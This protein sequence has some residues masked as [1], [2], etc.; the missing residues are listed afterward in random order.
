MSEDR[1]EYKYVRPLPCVR[2]E[3]GEIKEQMLKMLMSKIDEELN[4]F[5][6]AVINH[7]S[8]DLPCVAVGKNKV[9]WMDVAEEAADTI[10]A[11]T[12]LCSALG[13]DADMRSRAQDR[14]NQKNFRRGRL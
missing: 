9:F 14:V 7:Q 13:I 12:T 6:Q 8:F 2:D 4:E 10:T 1:A 11:I 5:K 3:R